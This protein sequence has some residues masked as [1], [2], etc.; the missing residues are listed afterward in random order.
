V[1][2][3]LVEKK[4]GDIFSLAWEGSSKGFKYVST[5]IITFSSFKELL[6]DNFAYF[7]PAK[8]ILGPTFL[9]IKLR[10]ENNSTT[11]YL[12]QG[13]YQAGGDWD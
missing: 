5:C 10:E 2:N 9:S 13:G 7:N 6:I 1:E 12:V 4:Q 3:C 11:L 8:Q